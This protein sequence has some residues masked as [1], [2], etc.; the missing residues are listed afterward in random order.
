MLEEAPFVGSW[1][2][3]G[4]EGGGG[5]TLPSIIEGEVVGGKT[6]LG[7]WIGERRRGGGS[8]LKVRMNVRLRRLRNLA[9]RTKLRSRPADSRRWQTVQTVLPFCGCVA[10]WVMNDFEAATTKNG[11]IIQPCI[12]LIQTM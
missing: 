6:S 4:D 11:P 10:P 12:L 1:I 7:A 8:G 3:G 5:D 9:K 2:V